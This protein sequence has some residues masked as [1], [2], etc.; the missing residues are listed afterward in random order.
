MVTFWHLTDVFT[1]ADHKRILTKRIAPCTSV[2]VLAWFIL[3][4]IQV[5]DRFPYKYL[6]GLGGIGG[7][8]ISH[9]IL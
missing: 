9:L 6:A 8:T 1:P 5:I 7:N 2:E 4:M 3:I